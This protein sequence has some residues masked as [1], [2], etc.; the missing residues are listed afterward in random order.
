MLYIKVKLGDVKTQLAERDL[1]TNNL[2][3][4]SDATLIYASL[5]SIE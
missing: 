2:G 3:I 5:V 4:V 1:K